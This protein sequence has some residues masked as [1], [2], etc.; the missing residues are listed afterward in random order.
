MIKRAPLNREEASSSAANIVHVARFAAA[1]QR[2][3]QFDPRMP[4][5]DNVIV[6]AF[7]TD[8][9]RMFALAGRARPTAALLPGVDVISE[10]PVP[11][12]SPDR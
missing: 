10:M 1:P 11:A 3:Q 12:A 8:F 9:S 5:A 2:V 7:G 6:P 4:I